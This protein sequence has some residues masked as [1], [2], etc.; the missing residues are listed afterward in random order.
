M[1]ILVILLIL[2]NIATIIL[3]LSKAQ[4]SNLNIKTE[5]QQIESILYQIL[6]QIK[7][8]NQMQ[9]IENQQAFRE[10]R[11]ELIN[12]IKLF[13]DTLSEAQKK[14]FEN[15]REIIKDLS[16]RTTERLNNFQQQLRENKQEISEILKTIEQNYEKNIQE[17]NQQQQTKLKEI[18]EKQEQLTKNTNEQLEKIR[19]SVELKLS[20]IIEE[21]N[22]KLEQMRQTVDEKLQT[23]LEKR[24]SESFK[25]VS[26]RLETVHKGLGEM[27]SIASEVG[28][29]KKVLTNVKTKGIIG[30][31]QL[32]N[33]LEN[34]LS[35]GQYQKN[36]KTKA[37]SNEVV[38]FAIV[39]P[40]KDDNKTPIFLPIDSKFPTE[41]YYRLLNAYETSN[42]EQI[43]EQTNNL[44]KTLKQFAKEI[45]EKY[46]N[47]P[48]TTDFAIMFLPVE[49]LYAEIVRNTSLIEELARD[50]RII[51][52][53]PTTLAALLNSLQM[54]FKTLAIEKRSTE[55]WKV[56]Q[57]VKT[58]FVK[59]EQL[60]IKA[61]E[62]IDKAGED[63]DELVGK[64]TKQINQ[65]LSNLSQLPDH[66]AK[67]ILQL[68]T[69]ADQEP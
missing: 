2:A 20:V 3:L 69:N 26:E 59:F 7:T 15:F 9:R 53:G 4:T 25:L 31:Y 44:H 1:E 64:R 8:E 12:N 30:E 62:K 32:A 39:L 34:I 41:H 19:S 42:T 48:Y 6:Q 56:L 11:Q 18:S 13:G 16:D 5:I 67:E 51:V 33:I 10:T 36:V 58:E 28:D 22:K 21:N 47:P 63:L 65:K 35:P 60:L 57:A 54:G 27:Q 37:G 23:T 61:K 43:K 46:I 14:D 40:G 50:F 55:V 24:L 17:L 52:S 45:K 66:E 49:G 38:E 68:N 29:L